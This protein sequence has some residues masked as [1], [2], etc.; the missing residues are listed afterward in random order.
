MSGR[1]RFRVRFPAKP[2]EHGV[3]SIVRRAG[4]RIPLSRVFSGSG[5]FSAG[6]EFRYYVDIIEKYGN[7]SLVE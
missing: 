1:G 2:L 5:G 3:R 4:A 6:R 7:H